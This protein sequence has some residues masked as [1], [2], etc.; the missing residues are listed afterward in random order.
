MGMKEE[1]V[2][3]GGGVWQAATTEE[4]CVNNHR[5]CCW[6]VGEKAAPVPG[7]CW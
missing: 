7:S 4:C 5:I 3:E 6:L 1:G 2:V